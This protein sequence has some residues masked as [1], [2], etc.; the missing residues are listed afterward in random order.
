M[1]V[2]RNILNDGVQRKQMQHEFVKLNLRDF[3]PIILDVYNLQHAL[4]RSL[5]HKGL[6]LRTFHMGILGELLFHD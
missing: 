6:L 1:D 5:K 4:M 3:W 2:Y